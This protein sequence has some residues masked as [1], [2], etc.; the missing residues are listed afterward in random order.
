MQCDQSKYLVAGG[1]YS[2]SI[3]SIAHASSRWYVQHVY[4]LVSIFT[5]TDL[6]LFTTLVLQLIAIGF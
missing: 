5:F 6:L 4:I 1:N 2:L 3:Y